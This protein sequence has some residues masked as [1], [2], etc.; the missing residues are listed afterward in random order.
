MV[1][2]ENSTKFSMTVLPPHNPLSF[3]GHPLLLHWQKFS[4]YPSSQLQVPHS[5]IPFPLIEKNIIFI[6]INAE[7]HQSYSFSLGI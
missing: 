3:F 1:N 2:N 6:G 4:E 7:N 5:Q